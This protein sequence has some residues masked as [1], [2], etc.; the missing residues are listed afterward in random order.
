MSLVEVARHRGVHMEDINDNKTWCLGGEVQTLAQVGNDQFMEILTG[1]GI[2]AQSSHAYIHFLNCISLP[3]LFTISEETRET[4]PLGPDSKLEWDHPWYILFDR[5]TSSPWFW[6]I[7]SGETT[8]VPL[9]LTGQVEER[10]VVAATNATATPTP[11]CPAESAP[12]ESDQPNWTCPVT[13]PRPAASAPWICPVCTLFRN[14]ITVVDS[15][16]YAPDSPAGTE[17]LNTRRHLRAMKHVGGGKIFQAEAM[18][19]FFT[20]IKDQPRPNL[21]QISPVQ[22]FGA[23]VARCGGDPERTIIH[24]TLV[25]P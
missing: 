15:A 23:Y 9:H 25:V 16:P 17:H 7:E 11:E 10:A 24:F 12:G 6:N 22:A 13:Y 8:R 2:H 19:E 18:T 5:E 14:E 4:I 1:L 3:E 21:F 20:Y